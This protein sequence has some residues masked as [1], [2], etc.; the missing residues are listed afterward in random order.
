MT[1]L[2]LLLSGCSIICPNL[3]A[4]S[5]VTPVR[6]DHMYNVDKLQTNP[7]KGDDDTKNEI[8]LVRGYF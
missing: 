2:T 6:K 3:H 8:D 5:A 1:L 4:V 7:A